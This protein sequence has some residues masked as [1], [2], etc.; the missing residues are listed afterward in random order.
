MTN[1]QRWN[2][3]SEVNYQTTSIN[4][5]INQTHV[6]RTI[7]QPSISQSID[8]SKHRR[9]SEILTS[10]ITTVSPNQIPKPLSEPDFPSRFFSPVN[11]T[12]RQNTIP[13]RIM[14]V[15][16]SLMTSTPSRNSNP[17]GKTVVKNNKK[18]KK[19]ILHVHTSK[20]GR[21]DR[22]THPNDFLRFSMKS[23]FFSLSQLT[24]AA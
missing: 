20:V 1:K 2:T 4:Q 17:R 5:S 16:F 10:W 21:T 23:G 7:D 9:E 19:V 12:S 11:A 13:L 6:D 14:A 8:R 18:Q 15:V 3:K 24:P 22:K